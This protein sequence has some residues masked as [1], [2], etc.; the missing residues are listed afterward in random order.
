MAGPF[1]DERYAY[2]VV[3]EGR[4]VAP[5]VV[6]GFVEGLPV[7]AGDENDG[8]RVRVVVGDGLQYGTDQRVVEEHRCLVEIQK[9]R[10]IEVVVQRDV[11]DRIETWLEWGLHVGRMCIGVRCVEEQ[12]AEE[13]SRAVTPVH[14]IDEAERGCTIA[15][16]DIAGA[17]WRYAI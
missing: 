12:E 7:I 11:V 5:G 8:V 15:F 13:R 14:R 10:G 2:L 4:V 17:G 1:H 16:D 3:G 6:M 9:W